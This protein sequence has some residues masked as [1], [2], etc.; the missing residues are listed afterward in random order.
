MSLYD[1]IIDQYT[2]SHAAKMVV[3]IDPRCNA[4]IPMRVLANRLSRI[5]VVLKSRVSFVWII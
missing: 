1:R 2:N 4:S 3:A 5:D